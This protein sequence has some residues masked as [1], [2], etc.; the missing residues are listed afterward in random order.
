MARLVLTVILTAVAVVVTLAMSGRGDPVVATLEGNYAYS[1]GDYV[2]A[3]IR[4]LQ[5][6]SQLA[7]DDLRRAHLDFNLANVYV[8][9]GEL[10]P[11]WATLRSAAERQVPELQVAIA[12]NLGGVLFQMGRYAEAAAAFRDALLV[13]PSL[14][15]AKINLELAL[16]KMATATDAAQQSEVTANERAGTEAVLEFIRGRETAATP[17]PVASGGGY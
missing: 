15:D 6:D 14:A 7:D 5:L 3:T 1:R 10:E 9:L 2:G 4:Y 8:S 17:P 13:D 11:G 12:Y 16:R